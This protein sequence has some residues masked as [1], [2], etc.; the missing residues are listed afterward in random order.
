VEGYCRSEIQVGGGDRVCR[1]EFHRGG[2]LGGRHFVEE[3]EWED[4]IA[5]RYECE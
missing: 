2:E 5:L 4:D 3:E 1:Q